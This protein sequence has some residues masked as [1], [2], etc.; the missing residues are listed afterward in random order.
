LNIFVSFQKKYSSRQQ[1]K[2]LLIS[3]IISEQHKNSR[4][5]MRSNNNNNT[6]FLEGKTFVL[7]LGKTLG[8]LPFSERNELNKD[9]HNAGGSVLSLVADPDNITAVI[10]RTSFTAQEFDAS[11]NLQA[12]VRHGIPVVS[13]AFLKA[14]LAH[15]K[16]VSFAP[17]LVEFPQD[18]VELKAIIKSQLT[19][20]SAERKNNWIKRVTGRVFPAEPNSTSLFVDKVWQEEVASKKPESV[21]GFLFRDY[22]EEVSEVNHQKTDTSANADLKS[23]PPP[24]PK[25]PNYSVVRSALFANSSSQFFKVELHVSSFGSEEKQKETIQRLQK[26]DPKGNAAH[27][28]HEVFQFPFRI[29]QYDQTTSVRT[30]TK[31]S[32]C[33]AITSTNAEDFFERQVDL[34]KMKFGEGSQ[35]LFA[36]VPGIGSKVALND[37]TS[38]MMM[39]VSS[40]KSPLLSN[41]HPQTID[42]VKF[43]FQDAY[44][45][46]R[47][48]ASAELCDSA[49]S[50]SLSLADVYKADA[51]L[52][53]INSV[54]LS[55]LK[56]KEK[57]EKE[58]Q[59]SCQL[60]D[61]FTSED[62]KTLESASKDFFSVVKTSD[63]S[64]TIINTL[65]LL[66]QFETVTMAL[67]GLLNVGE[68]NLV[69]TNILQAPAQ[70]QYSALDCSINRLESASSVERLQN[71]IDKYLSTQKHHQAKIKNVFQLSRA[72]EARRFRQTPLSWN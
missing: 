36:S 53:R 1:K 4:K 22:D 47:K 69:G 18:S 27:H 38:L 19:T 71:E 35:R 44:I 57:A 33:F 21:E 59:T 30:T 39:S 58:Q 2:V 66:Q 25:S 28:H 42:L 17:F 13:V 70:V 61:F 29:V 5:K 72:G 43:L 49:F 7:E 26:E 46:L 14:C 34:A 67:R 63:Y 68:S 9:I 31:I 24:F 12:A 64:I 37:L 45:M 55:A 51:A 10:T 41:L 50:S 56:K 65:D 52:A 23:H 20:S 54:F 15:K 32:A 8:L 40:S 62:N 11:L 3:S 16:I 48:R 6:S 60:S